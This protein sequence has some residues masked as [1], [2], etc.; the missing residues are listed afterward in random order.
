MSHLSASDRLFDDLDRVAQRRQEIAAQLALIAD[1]LAHAEVVGKQLSG[2]LA[3]DRAIRDVRAASENL[4]QGVFRLLVLGDMKR[5][6]STLINALI[7]ENLLPSDVNPCTALLT[8]LKYG[9]EKAVTV[10]FNDGTPATIADFATFKQRYRI[11]PEE[12]KAIEQTEQLAFPTVSYAVV[13]HPLPLLGKGIELVD[14]P[15]LNETEARNELSLGYLYNCH[16]VLFVL[17][18]TQPCTLDERR[19]LQNYLHDRG[20]SI[21]FLINAWDQVRSGL[22]DPEDAAALHE[23]ETRLRQVFRSHL[24]KY[25]QVNGQDIY[26][27]RVFELS[28]LQALRSRIRNPDSLL[29]GTGVPQFLASL[30]QFLTEERASAEFQHARTIGCR[31][32]SQVQSA[33]ARRIPLLDQSVAELQTR[34]AAVQS[35]FEQ[36][37]QIGQDFQQEI[38]RLGEQEASAIADSFASYILELE[39]SFETDFMQAQPDLDFMQF[40]NR[41][42]RAAFYTAMKRAFERYM[43]DRLAAWEFIAKQKLAATFSLLDTRANVYRGE[44]AEVVEA[45]NQKL[46]SERFYAAEHSYNPD[47]AS[48]FS[49]ALADLFASIPDGLNEAVRSF[50]GFW[51]NVFFYACVAIALNMVG[52]LFASIT[53]PFVGALL[54]G[55]GLVALQAETVRQQFIAAAKQEFVK[56]LPKLAETQRQPIYQAVKKCFSVYESQVHDRIQADI[57]ARRLELENLL[58]Q[59][60]SQEIDRDAERQRLQQLE[61][62]LA[63]NLQRIDAVMREQAATG[64]EEISYP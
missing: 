27:R 49:D 62:S 63:L 8:I 18:A 38:H 61:I 26:D 5:G 21:F 53:L 32:Y 17:S 10:H 47:Q 2:Q 30:S 58:N 23:A 3:L 64:A 25:C 55:V 34:I 41:S 56:C 15:G 60:R 20:L 9:P 14:T 54:L 48:T 13:E 51:Q 43:N 37:E 46:F 12:T 28:S 59:K 45:M 22:F 31:V 35:D 19:Y 16:A 1:Q 29:E 11:S 39:A 24:T 40:A 42:N 52:L 6:K 44:Y 57:A 33:I 4:R 50:N 36:L 7:G